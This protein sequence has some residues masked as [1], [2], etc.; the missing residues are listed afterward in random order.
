M[1]KLKDKILDMWSKGL[2][3]KGRASVYLGLLNTA[4]IFKLFWD[5]FESPVLAMVLAIVGVST[6]ATLSIFDWKF[7]HAKYAGGIWNSNTEFRKLKEKIDNIEKKI[8]D[9]K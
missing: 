1:S 7:I 6:L 4:M 8:D 9:L 2:I 5:S 3:L